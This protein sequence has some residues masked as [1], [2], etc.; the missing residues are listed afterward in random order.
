M[1]YKI[2]FSDEALNNLQEN[3]NYLFK[4]WSDKV[5]IE[6]ID[7]LY[8]K[9][10]LI[11]FQPYSYSK[12]YSNK[13]IRKCV[14]TKQISLIYKIIGKKVIILSLFDTRQSPDKLK[15]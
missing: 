11:S 10:E 13:Q 3:L 2:E 14:V 15:L 8:F 6:F 9:L 5:A 12:S 7:K 1:A 4:E